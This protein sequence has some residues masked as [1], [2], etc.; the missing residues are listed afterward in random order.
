MKKSSKEKS[1]AFARVRVVINIYSFLFFL[2]IY[3]ILLGS[4]FRTFGSG[5]RTGY[6]EN[7]TFGSVNQSRV[8]NLPKTHCRKL[9][10]RYF[11][12]SLSLF[13]GVAMQALPLTVK[14]PDLLKM[15]RRGAETRRCNMLS[16]HALHFAYFNY[17]FI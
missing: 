1:S 3:S 10:I 5:F 7:R 15:L 6:A 9:I 14:H 12:S 13:G 17:Y 2:F 4:V 16:R 11:H 8:E